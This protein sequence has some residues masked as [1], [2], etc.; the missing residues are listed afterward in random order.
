MV[1][2]NGKQE[3]TWH[4]SLSIVLEGLAVMGIHIRDVIDGKLTSTLSARCYF[5]IGAIVVTLELFCQHATE[6]SYQWGQQFQHHL[7]PSVHGR[8]DT[9]L[10]YKIQIMDHQLS[11]AYEYV[12]PCQRIVMT[13]LT[14]R[15]C[16]S[17]ALAAL[18]FRCGAM[19]GN[20]IT[21]KTSL[22]QELSYVSSFHCSTSLFEIELSNLVR[23][24]GGSS[25][26]QSPLLF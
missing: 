25:L 24:D 19:M 15:C 11:Y 10:N 4:R 14:E 2:L 17:L 21:G 18:T 5:D 13:P 7:L 20:A 16:H 8:P 22:M 23:V 26:H 9:K 12:G 6:S 1:L 3:E